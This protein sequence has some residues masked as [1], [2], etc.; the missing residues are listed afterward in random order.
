MRFVN[1]RSDRSAFRRTTWSSISA[2]VILAVVVLL[3]SGC[4]PRT[5]TEL[6]FAPQ[7]YRSPAYKAQEYNPITAEL[8][9]MRKPPVGSVAINEHPYRYTLADSLLQDQMANPFPATEEVL[10]VG[11]KYYD[12][13]CIVCHG[14]KGD[15]MGYIIPKGMQMPPSYVTGAARS[16]SDGRMYHLI[17]R[18]RG[19][20]A[21]YAYQLTPE[22]RWAVVH[23]IRA[24][25]RAGNP[26][27]ADLQKFKS[28][29]IGFENDEPDTTYG[30]LWPKK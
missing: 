4:G 22:Q 24:L 20:M 9:V 26:S 11:K 10:K 18:G 25:Q 21:S 5:R 8:S 2:I 29:G 19:N 14:P 3:M 1:S 23:Y 27:T 16:W 17:T 28:G 30:V 13:Y 6:E 7:M 12:V 15:G